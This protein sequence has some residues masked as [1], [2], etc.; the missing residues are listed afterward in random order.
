MGSAFSN[1]ERA[2]LSISDLQGKE[3]GVLGEDEVGYN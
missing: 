3:K 1:G 2:K